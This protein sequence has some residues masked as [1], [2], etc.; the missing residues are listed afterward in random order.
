VFGFKI[1]FASK[2]RLL[3][4][5]WHTEAEHPIIAQI[6]GAKPE[7]FEKVAAIMIIIT[8]ETIFTKY[9]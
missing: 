6:F 8:I 3:V 4:D 5:L 2:E 7:Q 1:Q 9:F